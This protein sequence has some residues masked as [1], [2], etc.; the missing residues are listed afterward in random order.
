LIIDSVVAALK[1]TFD[2]VVNYMANQSKSM[3]VK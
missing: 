3:T 1:A 2:S